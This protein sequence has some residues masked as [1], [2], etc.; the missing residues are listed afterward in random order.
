MGMSFL[1]IQHYR[2]LFPEGHLMTLCDFFFFL[3][4]V[5]VRIFNKVPFLNQEKEHS[6]RQSVF[7]AYLGISR[8]AIIS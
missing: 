1:G 5:S 2:I 8:L 6:V 7:T 4:F 3:V